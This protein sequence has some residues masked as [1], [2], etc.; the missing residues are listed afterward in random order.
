MLIED[1]TSFDDLIAQLRK[2]SV[3]YLDTEF[4]SEKSYRPRLCLLQIAAGDTVCAV[5]PFGVKDI[6][7][8]YELLL[9]PKVE[10]VVHS[11]QQDMMIFF[12]LMGTPPRGMFDT[13]KERRMWQPLKARLPQILFLASGNL[14]VLLAAGLLVVS[15]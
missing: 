14:I 7:A 2:E 8:F 11:G 10:K 4:I 12:D 1:Q 15:L 9:D 5:D 6:S 3:L 13:V